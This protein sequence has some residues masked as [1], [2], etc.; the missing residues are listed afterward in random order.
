MPVD[1]EIEKKRHRLGARKGGLISPPR[2]LREGKRGEEREASTGP[3]R[4]KKRLTD[5]LG[6][7]K[8]IT[9]PAHREKGT[10]AQKRSA[11]NLW[12]F[13]GEKKNPSI[14]AGYEKRR[15]HL[16]KRSLTDAWRERCSARVPCSEAGKRATR[17][18]VEALFTSAWGGKVHRLWN[19]LFFKGKT[20]RWRK[21]PFRVLKGNRTSFP[22]V[23][24]RG[25]GKSVFPRR[26][27][28][29]ILEGR[30][31]FTMPDSGTCRGREGALIRNMGNSTY[32]DG[33]A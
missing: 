5:S 31:P 3:A 12:L 21:M 4:K 29:P 30:A 6:W 26:V 1:R 27:R 16:L 24:P 19:K 11:R 10:R 25:M 33:L 14:T 15:S 18:R 13:S 9:R 7:E 23:L 2:F 8:E 17:S 32:F 28:G 22:F 20:L